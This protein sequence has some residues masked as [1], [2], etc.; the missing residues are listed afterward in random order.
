[1]GFVEFERAPVAD[2][3]VVM[4]LVATEVPALAL[5]VSENRKIE[6]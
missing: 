6:F 3:I 4:D 1:M 5:R 2:V